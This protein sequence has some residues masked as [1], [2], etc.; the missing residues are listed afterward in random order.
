[1]SKNWKPRKFENLEWRGDDV[2]TGVRMEWRSAWD[3]CGDR[4]RDRRLV[5][6]W[7]WHGGRFLGLVLAVGFLE[8]LA[9]GVVVWWWGWCLVVFGGGGMVARLVF[10]VTSVWIGAVI[11][12]LAWETREIF[13]VLGLWVYNY[14]PKPAWKR[15]DYAQKIKV[16]TKGTQ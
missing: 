6:L 13:S 10:V 12:F 15:K 14:K 3:R 16:R 8:V 9:V 11:W 2:E 5:G 4:H 7:W 1:M